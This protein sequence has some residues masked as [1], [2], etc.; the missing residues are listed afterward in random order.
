VLPV[1]EGRHRACRKCNMNIEWL[2]YE[3]IFQDFSCNS[4]YIIVNERTMN[5]R[6]CIWAMACCCH[7]CHIRCSQA[8]PANIIY[9]N[10][11]QKSLISPY[12]A[13]AR[14]VNMLQITPL[15]VCLAVRRYELARTT[16]ITATACEENVSTSIL[17]H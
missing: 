6:T 9:N 10:V 3:T 4:R 16:L 2:Y 15:R 1:Q 12:Q 17:Y 8:F 13:T 7:T 14:K 5:G 11:C